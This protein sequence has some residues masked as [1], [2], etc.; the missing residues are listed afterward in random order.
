VLPL[1][2]LLLLGCPTGPDG[3]PRGQVEVRLLGQPSPST[4][5]P[6]PWRAQ[7][8]AWTDA[9]GE[10]R[11]PDSLVLSWDEC[12]PQPAVAV[13][14]SAST[15]VLRNTGSAE[16]RLSWKGAGEGEASLS[17]GLERRLVLGGGR[18]LQIEDGTR[19]AAVVVAA[20]GRPLDADGAATMAS[21]PAGERTI[22]LTRVDGQT[23]TV[24]VQVPAASTAVVDF[25]ADGRA[26]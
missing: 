21:V 3:G 12:G 10:D 14:G 15:V 22:G 26:D 6:C 8:I 4:P 13:L 16:L 20:Q 7:A 24:R 19:S 18:V 25:Q 2:P 5:P 1:L 17:P 9:P 11:L 23:Q